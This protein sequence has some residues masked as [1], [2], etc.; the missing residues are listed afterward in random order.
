MLCFD[1]FALVSP[2]LGPKISKKGCDLKDGCVSSFPFE[3]KQMCSGCCKVGIVPP[4]SY[5]MPASLRH[6]SLSSLWTLMSVR[7][8]LAHLRLRT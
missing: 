8:P 7:P 1:E 2:A 5:K 4:G 6:P 3:L